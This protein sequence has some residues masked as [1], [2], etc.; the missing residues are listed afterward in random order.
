MAIGRGI[1][2]FRVSGRKPSH[3]DHGATQLGG[4]NLPVPF[5]GP[6]SDAIAP[7]R[8]AKGSDVKRSPQPG[9]KRAAPSH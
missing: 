1:L 8:A 9:A 2:R 3:G 4:D 7:P 6:A 5:A